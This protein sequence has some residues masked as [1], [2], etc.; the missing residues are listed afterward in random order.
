MSSIYSKWNIINPYAWGPLINSQ[1]N[2]LDLGVVSKDVL[3]NLQASVGYQWNANE[4]IGNRFARLSYQGFFPVIDFNFES[5]SRQTTLNLPTTANKFALSSDQWNQNKYSLGIRIPFNLTHSAF[6]ETL[7]FGSK[8]ELWQVSGYELQRRYISEA[9]NGTYTSVNHQFSYAKLFNRTYRDLQ[10]K[11]GIQLVGRLTTSP[12]KQ[13][14]QAELWSLQSKIYLPG[15]MSHHGIG[16][17][18]GYQQESKGNYR[19]TSNLVFPRGYSYASFDNMVSYSLDYRFP[20]ISTDLNLG[21]WFYL[22]RI[23]SD[24]FMDGG[25]GQT[26]QKTQK[27]TR[28]YQSIGVD[29]SFQFHLM[30]FSQ[31][32]EVGVR[33]VYL[34]QS[35]EVAWYPLV[36]DIG[37]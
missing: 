30:R 15:L 7:E 10:S 20:V 2:G 8:L 6:Q 22:K 13:S 24:I 32:F 17:R 1:G 16:V 36:L 31:E 21:R 34:P 26:M 18:L 14:L 25:R 29:L 23:N 19:F 35:K 28:D 12:F 11:W 4:Q 37:F 5:G 3:N 33:G 27:N 9:F